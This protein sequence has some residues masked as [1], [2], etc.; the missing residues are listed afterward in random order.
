VREPAEA[1]LDPQQVCFTFFP[2][3]GMAARGVEQLGVENLGPMADAFAFQG[4]KDALP[5]VGGM[6]GG[7]TGNFDEDEG[8]IVS[9]VLG[10]REVA[11]LA[12]AEKGAIPK[13]NGEVI[14]AA[15]LA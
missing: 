5:A 6:L 13:M 11:R 7:P 12:D 4:I 1:F 14:Q 8:G 2:E 9:R 10:Q 15:F 3:N